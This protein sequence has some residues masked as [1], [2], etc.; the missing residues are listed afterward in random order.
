VWS[1]S[2]DIDAYFICSTSLQLLGSQLIPP[3]ISATKGRRRDAHIYPL[4]A[5]LR[6]RDRPPLLLQC[7][8]EPTHPTRSGTRLLGVAAAVFAWLA[9]SS[10]AFPFPIPLLEPYTSQKDGERSLHA[11][12]PLPSLLIRAFSALLCP[13][14]IP[15]ILQTALQRL[16]K[17]CH[18]FWFGNACS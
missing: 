11:R 5:G 10:H 3:S 9:S 4:A 8:S 17:F 18:F 15:C 14:Y 2:D 1:T 7:F 12:L 6:E 16:I 13:V